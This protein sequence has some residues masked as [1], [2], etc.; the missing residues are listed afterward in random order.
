MIFIRHC[1]EQP[2][3]KT[4]IPVLAFV[5][6]LFLFPCSIKGEVLD[7][8]AVDSQEVV[9]EGINFKADKFG[10]EKV[11]IYFNRFY[12][13]KIFAIEG[14]KPRIVIDVDNVFSWQGK[15][16][17]DVEGIFVKKIRTHLDSTKRRLRIVLDLNPSRNYVAD[18]SYFKND[19]I[20]CIMI[21]AGTEKKAGTDLEK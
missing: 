19:N 9:V 7:K 18:Q 10:P 4:P 20:F 13:P 5:L 14:K 21:G 1:M 8:K 6:F 2:M 12:L 16:V 11:L 3:K 15:T 17:M